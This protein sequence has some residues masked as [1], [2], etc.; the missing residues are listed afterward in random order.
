MMPV[1]FE[2]F[3]QVSLTPSVLLLVLGTISGTLFMSGYYLVG[4]GLTALGIVAFIHFDKRERKFEA[5]LHDR[6]SS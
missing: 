2:E 4:A 6:P 3:M 1:V 5:M